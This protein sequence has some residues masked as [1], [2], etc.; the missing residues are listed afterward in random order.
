MELRDLEANNERPDLVGRGFLH[1]Y[2]VRMGSSTE[3]QFVRTRKGTVGRVFPKV[4]EEGLIARLE[5]SE[6]NFINSLR[7]KGSRMVEDRRQ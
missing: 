4:A 3:Q 6:A 1:L 7:R 5:A 2:V